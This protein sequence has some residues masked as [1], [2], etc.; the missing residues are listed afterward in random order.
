MVMPPPP[1]SDDTESALIQRV[2]NADREAFNE[3]Y[4]LYQKRVF[5]Y[6]TK[7]LSARETAEEVFQDV[8]FDLWRQARSFR[9]EARAATWIFGIAHH[10][11]MNSLRSRGKTVFGELEEADGKQAGTDD[12]QAAAERSE[13]GRKMGAALQQLSA[14]HRAVVELTFYHGF[15]YAE[16]AQIANCP[17]NTVKTRMFHAR[18][19]LREL[20]S[21]MGFG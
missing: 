21:Q 13:L 3:L 19:Q 5:A 18:R 14:E 10:K 11:A 2:A 9:R 12:P 15:S 6:L 7:L 1:T 16:I 17:L 8:M 4:A 20:L